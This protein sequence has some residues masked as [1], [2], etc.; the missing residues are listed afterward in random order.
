MGNK[1]NSYGS[2]RRQMKKE[3]KTHPIWR[4]VGFAFMILIPI[5]AYAGMRVLM[6]QT[7]LITSKMTPD[8]LVQPK[9]FL[10]PYVNDAFYVEAVTFILLLIIFF[11]IFTFVSF[12]I[13]SAAGITAKNDPF[14]VPPPPKHKRRR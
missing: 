14:Y 12:M 11:A 10:W 7:D 8:M 3:V 5:M 9:D 1:Y 2:E 4:G 6:D 13:T